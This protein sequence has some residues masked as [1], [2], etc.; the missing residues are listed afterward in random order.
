VTPLG[1]VAL[2]IG[3]MWLAVVALATVVLFTGAEHYP[4]NS[5]RSTAITEYHMAGYVMTLVVAS[6]LAVLAIAIA[7]V[8]AAGRKP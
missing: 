5:L 7:C 4:A 1:K 6:V 2:T 8:W 3:A